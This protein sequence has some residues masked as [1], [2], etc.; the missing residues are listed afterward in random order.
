M[1]R[2]M[3]VFVRK[4]HYDLTQFI[5]IHRTHVHIYAVSTYSERV[6]TT[7]QLNQNGWDIIS[8]IWFA[9]MSN[10]CFMPERTMFFVYHIWYNTTEIE[11]ETD[12]IKTQHC[13]SIEYSNVC[14]Q[15]I[16]FFACL[17]ALHCIAMHLEKSH[18]HSNSATK[19]KK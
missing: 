14:T 12:K 15:H 2:K 11:R 1:L 16:F 17:F 18:S 9:F 7:K 19:R 5:C 13:P 6:C 3:C 10:A 4:M 8:F